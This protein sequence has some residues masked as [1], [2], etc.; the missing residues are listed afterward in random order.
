[1][2]STDQA[3]SLDKVV[4][5]VLS[6]GAE[7]VDNVQYSGDALNITSGVN[8]DYDDFRQVVIGATSVQ[9]TADVLDVEFTELEGESKLR[10]TVSVE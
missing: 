1:M 10:A 2:A 7:L 3:N 9:E 8:V 6:S 5:Y 4:D